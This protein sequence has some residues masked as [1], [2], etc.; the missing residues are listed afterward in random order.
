M[1]QIHQGGRNA[2]RG[3]LKPFGGS[4]LQVY[5]HLLIFLIIRL[6]LS[7]QVSGY[8]GNRP[9]FFRI[10]V[11]ESQIHPHGDGV[12]VTYIRGDEF[13]G[14]TTYEAFAEQVGESTRQADILSR[15]FTHLD[16]VLIGLL[17]L[18]IIHILRRYR[19]R[20]LL[21]GDAVE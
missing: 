4:H 19:P 13:G 16:V 11:V 8:C 2:E 14:D 12:V 5:R 10:V 17:H 3:A 6:E 20:S 7:T 18:A 9:F 21:S 1:V 15:E